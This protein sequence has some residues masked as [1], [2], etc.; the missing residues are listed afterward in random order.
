MSPSGATAP[1]PGLHRELSPAPNGD[2]TRSAEGRAEKNS[3]P[4]NQHLRRRAPRVKKKPKAETNAEGGS[5]AEGQAEASSSNRKQR[6]R[7]PRSRSIVTPPP[8]T[9]ITTEE[10]QAEVGWMKTGS[11]SSSKKQQGKDSSTRKYQKTPSNGTKVASSAAQQQRNC[12]LNPPTLTPGKPI[13]KEHL[14][15][16]ALVSGLEKG[17]LFRAKL[18]CNPGDRSQGFCTIP[19][20]PHDVFIPDWKPQNR[21]VEGD[22]VVIQLLPMSDWRNQNTPLGGRGNWKTKRTERKK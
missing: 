7:N 8:A 4:R 10:K 2:V 22:E 16:D 19:G 9:N 20:L 11:A 1:P 5:E 6:T 13:F 18:R 3:K 12:R 21:A 14:G 17:T 15:L